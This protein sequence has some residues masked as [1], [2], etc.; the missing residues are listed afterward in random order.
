MGRK[1]G[2]CACIDI[3]CGVDEK[4]VRNEIRCVLFRFFF[5]F[6]MA[7]HARGEECAS[8]MMGTDGVMYPITTIILAMSLDLC[9]L[10][11]GRTRLP[12]CRAA[13]PPQKKIFFH[14]LL[15][16]IHPGVFSY[17]Y[18]L[19]FVFLFYRLLFAIRW[20]GSDP[21]WYGGEVGER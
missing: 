3:E 16:K 7:P 11:G 13:E 19:L 18:I 6:F 20:S 2:R 5:S 21:D 15:V 9:W 17:L 10:Q 12:G 8:L 1:G 4:G 14:L